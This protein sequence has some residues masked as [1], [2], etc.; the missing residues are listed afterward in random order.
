MI[1]NKALSNLGYDCHSLADGLIKIMTPFTQDDGDVIGIYVEQLADDKFLITDDARTLMNLECRGISISA[2]RFDAIK[3]ILMRSGVDLSSRAEINAIANSETLSEQ[4]QRVVQGTIIASGC[5][6]NW[7]S[8]PIADKFEKDV[9]GTF[10]D[11][12]QH[13][14]QELSFDCEFTGASGHQIKVPIMLSGADKSTKQIFT[15]SVTGSGSWSSAYSVLGKIIDLSDPT[16][17]DTTKQQFVVIDDQ[18]IGDQIDNLIL[19]FNSQAKVLPYQK[20]EIW[21][22]QL[23]A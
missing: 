22:A 14:I 11:R 10:R 16:Y 1:C 8:L 19:L 3:N 4:M 9:K 20:R 5:S 12:K 18:A 17:R 2:K 21:I 7:F 15:A 13:F 6:S 23:A